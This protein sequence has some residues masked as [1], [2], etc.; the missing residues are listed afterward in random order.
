MA[1]TRE[2]DN[3]C[4]KSWCGKRATVEVF[5][6]QNTSY[7]TFCRKCGK[8]RARLLTEED[9]AEFNRRPD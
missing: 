4:G 9:K 8:D 2:L 3:K 5:N 6:N 1:Y 7:G